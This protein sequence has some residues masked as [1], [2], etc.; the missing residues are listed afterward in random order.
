MRPQKNSMETADS[1]LHV[2]HMPKHMHECTWKTPTLHKLQF[3]HKCTL[4]YM[5]EMD[6]G[7]GYSTLVWVGV[8][9]WEFWSATTHHPS[10]YQFWRKSDP[11]MYHGIWGQAHPCTTVYNFWLPIH[12][13][14]GKI[15][16]WRYQ[17]K[18]KITTHHGTSK[19]FRPMHV[20]TR[21]HCEI[22]ETWQTWAD[23]AI[24]I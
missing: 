24:K 4:H 10:M 21:I 22:K 6:P 2:F 3:M 1:P 18:A 23:W 8:C 19:K 14:V 16:P 15:H 9:L 7:G 5:S 12:V 13:P 11:S 17:N 20:P